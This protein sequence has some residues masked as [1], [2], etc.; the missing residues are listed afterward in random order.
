MRKLIKTIYIYSDG[1]REES[2]ANNIYDDEEFINLIRSAFEVSN[3][4]ERIKCNIAIYLG[5]KFI[6]DKNYYEEK[7]YEKLISKIVNEIISKM[8]NERKIKNQSIID[9]TS[10]Q[11]GISQY[12]YKEILGDAIAGNRERLILLLEE[13][14]V[15]KTREDDL[16][17][18]R[19][20]LK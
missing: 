6:Y 16:N 17:L 13:N 12:R 14:V 9:K 3:A 5:T 19:Q 20:Y 10:R 2:I 18:I 11:L 7:N 15:D 8:A 1:S 4:S